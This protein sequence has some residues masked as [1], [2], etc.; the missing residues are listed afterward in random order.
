MVRS[1]GMF[2]FRER[3]TVENISRKNV[4][5]MARGQ[6]IQIISVNMAA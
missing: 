1:Q 5:D 3:M 4:T 2:V 6:G